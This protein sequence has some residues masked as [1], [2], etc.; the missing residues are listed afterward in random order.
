MDRKITYE[1]VR[2]AA[3]LLLALSTAVGLDA[4][5]A[6]ES[7][8]RV[9]ENL[10]LGLR[11]GTWSWLALSPTD[12]ELLVVSSESGYVFASGDGGTSWTEA[13]LIVETAAFYGAIRPSP[14]ATGAGVKSKRLQSATGRLGVG[15]SYGLSGLHDFD[16][17]TT[18][19]EF[20]DAQHYPTAYDGVRLVAP[21]E[22]YDVSL[23]GIY[24]PGFMSLR[25]SGGGEGGGG[26]SARLGVGLKS[27]APYLESM[28]RRMKMPT[29][30]LCIKGLLATQG[31]EP[32]NVNMTAVHP[33]DPR[34]ILAASAMGLF[35]SRNR[36]VD[37]DLLYGGSNAGER[38]ARFVVFDPLDPAT[39]LL[40][41][42]KGLLISRDGGLR[43][44]L[45]SGTQLSS[46]TVNAVVFDPQRPGRILV[47]TTIGAF[48]SRDA[49][50][51][52]RWIFYETLKAANYVTLAGTSPQDEGLVYLSTGDGLFRSRDGGLT[53]GRLGGLLFT[54]T[55]I[56]SLVVDP[57]DG[58]HLFVGT[59]RNV[60]ESR[61]RGHT[62]AIVYIDDAEW[63]IRALR[64]DPHDPEVLWI[65]TSAELLRLSPAP[66]DGAPRPAATT[67]RL[68]ADAGPSLGQVLDRSFRAMRVHTGERMDTRSR[69]S[70]AGLLPR[71]ALVAGFMSPG[72][73][74]GI[75]Y[76]PWTEDRN[77]SLP[78]LFATAGNKDAYWALV[79][80]KWD[81]GRMVYNRDALPFGRV[82]G[83]N[84]GIYLTL[85]Y[86]IIR[87]YEE[88]GRIREA[89]L[90]G[91]A[92]DDRQRIALELRY[93]ELTQY[94]NVYTDGMFQAEIRDARAGAREE[95]R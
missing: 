90:Q 89:L 69:A 68:P 91:A 85:K 47:T 2:T 65:V 13:R 45:V 24:D 10:C 80:L 35:V 54:G 22:Y 52:W 95:E 43:F 39:V 31:R 6:P 11:M 5:A 58:D 15:A 86:E 55:W 12:P 61:D 73:L 9:K 66:L 33:R 84:N 70:W 3:L 92:L 17:G 8:R 72:G 50:R 40:G 64:V 67:L 81:I 71:A 94:L 32:T 16:F 7:T 78:R 62:W 4:R 41:T 25:Y 53:W 56:S 42:R 14:A 28:L 48:E 51:T 49:G 34:M 19:Q 18:G 87:L 21:G 93:E 37:W 82:F 30:T 74:S 76:L 38:E 77:L 60:W 20:L 29:T 83:Q 63:W 27:A 26:A 79:T 57:R 36:G 88:R 75:Q 23:G 46:A 1:R 44:D 59:N